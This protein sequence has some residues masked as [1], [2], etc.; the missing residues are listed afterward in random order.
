[1]RLP[2]LALMERSLRVDARRGATYWLRLLLGT[3]SPL[4][5][6]GVH[7]Q[8]T[9]LCVEED[10]SKGACPGISCS[11]LRF[12]SCIGLAVVIGDRAILL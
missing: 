11:T 3:M 4:D 12:G 9:S 6:G 10:L 8:R 2:V 5:H 7:A 1:M